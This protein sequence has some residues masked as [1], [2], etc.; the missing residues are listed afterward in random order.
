[1]SDGKLRRDE[2]DQRDGGGGGGDEAAGRSRAD[3][4]SSRCKTHTGRRA[5]GYRVRPPEQHVSVPSRRPS[6]IQ[7]TPREHKPGGAVFVCLLSV[8]AGVEARLMIALC[9][10]GKVKRVLS[11]CKL[12]S[13]YRRRE[14]R[15]RIKKRV[16]R[17]EKNNRKG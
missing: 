11:C 5:G 4:L 13:A 17:N 16:K 7:F 14:K 10:D 12:F 2:W 3:V 8:F 15:I 9:G 6:L 1:M